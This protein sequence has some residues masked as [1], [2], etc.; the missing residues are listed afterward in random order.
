M[1]RSG[2]KALVAKR[3]VVERRRGRNQ[4]RVRKEI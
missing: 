2:E 3:K 1:G 4:E